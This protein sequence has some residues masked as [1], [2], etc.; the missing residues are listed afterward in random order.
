MTDTAAHTRLIAILAHYR[1][2]PTTDDALKAAVSDILAPADF[3]AMTGAAISQRLDKG[4]GRTLEMGRAIRARI[5][6]SNASDRS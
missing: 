1:P 4:K 2:V 6:E 3:L 5:E